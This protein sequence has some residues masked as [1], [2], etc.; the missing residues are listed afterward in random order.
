MEPSQLNS[1][2]SHRAVWL[3]PSSKDA[4][5]NSLMSSSLPFLSVYN[6]SQLLQHSWVVHRWPFLTKCTESKLFGA[7][8]VKITQWMTDSWCQAR[9]PEFGSPAPTQNLSTLGHTSVTPALGGSQEHSNQSV[10]PI[11]RSPGSVREKRTPQKYSETTEHH[12][13]LLEEKGGAHGP[14]PFLRIYIQLR[15]DWGGQDISSVM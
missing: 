14:H 3:V 1:A 10:Y 13:S 4:H 2:A 9:G 12:Q 5:S 7:G 6:D 15:V 11:Q 8:V